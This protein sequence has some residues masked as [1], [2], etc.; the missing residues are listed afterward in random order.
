MLGAVK[1]K[2]E[3][4][5]YPLEGDF[6][7]GLWPALKSWVSRGHLAIPCERYAEGQLPFVS[8]LL[9]ALLSASIPDLAGVCGRNRSCE[10][11]RG[12]GEVRLGYSAKVDAQNPS[13]AKLLQ[14]TWQRAMIHFE[15]FF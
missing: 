11:L 1:A 3:A 4:F 7:P 5:T 13:K 2:P 6:K 14:H 8:I 12:A 10:T 15:E 9:M